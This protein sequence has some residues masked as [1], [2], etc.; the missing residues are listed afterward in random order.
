MRALAWFVVCAAVLVG[1]QS[2]RCAKSKLPSWRGPNAFLDG[3]LPSNRKLHGFT[4]CDDGT[5]MIYVFG[6]QDT[7]KGDICRASKV[8]A[9]RLAMRCAC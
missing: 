5:D 4:T 6:G 9:P 7:Q 8:G 1:L 2:G 3:T